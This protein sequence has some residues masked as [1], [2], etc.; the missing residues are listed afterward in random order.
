MARIRTIKPEF[1]TDEN[2]SAISAEACLLAIGLLNYADDEGFFKANPKLVEAAIFPLRELS[3]SIHGA[4]IELSNIGYIR[5]CEGDDGKKYGEIVNF[6][7]HQKVNRPNPSK[8]KDLCKFTEDSLKTHGILTDGIGI[9]KGIGKGIGR[10]LCAPAINPAETKKPES[11]SYQKFLSI[12]PKS[13][14]FHSPQLQSAFFEQVHKAD[15]EEVIFSA[16]ELYTK[17][18]NATNEQQRFIPKPEKWLNEEQWRTDWLLERRKY[19]DS[20][21]KADP[22]ELESIMKGAKYV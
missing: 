12:Y 16:V 17:Y 9:G 15:G 4:L 19:F 11:G 7:K 18:L 2:L 20:Q 21:D 10:D 3:L 13:G 8:I 6:N 22:E 14:N 1:W 5:L